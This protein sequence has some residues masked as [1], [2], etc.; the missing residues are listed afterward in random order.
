MIGEVLAGLS[1]LSSLFGSL[2]SAQANTAIDRQLE[3]RQMDLD[4]WY[5][6]EYNINYLD[7]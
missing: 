5:N 1:A 7:T 3:R 2:K 4:T 6:K